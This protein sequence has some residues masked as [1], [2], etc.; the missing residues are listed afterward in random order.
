MFDPDQLR[1]CLVT[2]RDLSLGRSLLDVV[3]AAVQGGATMVQL[4]EKN[5]T[6]REFLDLVCR[7]GDAVPDEVAVI[8]NDRVDVF[9]AARRLGARVSGMHL[10]QSDLQPALARELIGGLFSRAPAARAA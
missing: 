8:V 10:G 5:A 6:A 7:V 1:L 4:R 3:G 2:D 9:L